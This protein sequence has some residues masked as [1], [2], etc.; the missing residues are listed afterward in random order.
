MKQSQGRGD[1]DVVAT[2]EL[3]WEGDSIIIKLIV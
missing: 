3:E 1:V 2:R